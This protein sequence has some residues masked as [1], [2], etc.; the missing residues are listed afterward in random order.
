MRPTWL[1]KVKPPFRKALQICLDI[2]PFLRKKYKSVHSTVGNLQY[3]NPAAPPP[4]ISTLKILNNML[5]LYM[6]IHPPD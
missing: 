2:L 1:K 5:P 6:I 3:H 4:P